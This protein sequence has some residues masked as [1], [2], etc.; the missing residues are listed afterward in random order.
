MLQMGRVTFCLLSACL[1]VIL[2]CQCDATIDCSAV[3]CAWVDEK[4]CPGKYT[5]AETNKGICCPDCIVTKGEFCA[6]SRLFTAER[7]S[8]CASIE[9]I[10]S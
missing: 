3:K 5:K 4:D 7:L 9:M 2:A 6:S 10:L 1:L 8:R